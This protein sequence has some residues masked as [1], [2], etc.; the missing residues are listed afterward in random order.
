MKRTVYSYGTEFICIANGSDIEVH[1]ADNIFGENGK[2]NGE[3]GYFIGKI[4]GLSLPS[5]ET[6]EEFDEGINEWL[7]KF[8]W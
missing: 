3:Y 8:F 5:E 1:K 4:E 7:E 6:E 2:Y